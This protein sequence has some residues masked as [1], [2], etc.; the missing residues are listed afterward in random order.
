MKAYA[1]A[2][3]KNV[4]MGPAIVTYL[5]KID[6]TL[7]PFGGKFVIHGGP[8]EALE[9]AVADAVI[10]IGFP[11]MESARAW[12]ASEAYQAIL[13]LRTA[14]SEGSAFLVHGVDADHKATDVLS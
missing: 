13:P 8:I 5:E 12:Y 2:Q 7:A 9:G 1:I 4:V 3:L 11:H 6:E 10:M 14:N